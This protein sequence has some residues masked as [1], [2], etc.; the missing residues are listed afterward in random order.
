MSTLFFNLS[1]Q[2]DAFE[3]IQLILDLFDHVFTLPTLHDLTQV[4]SMFSNF[5][6]AGICKE[7]FV[8][9]SCNHN[10]MSFVTFKHY[11]VSPHDNIS[12]LFQK[13][14]KKNMQYTCNGCQTQ[15]M[16]VV[17]CSL[18]D[19][20]KILLLLVNRFSTSSLYHRNRKNKAP[21]HIYENIR[22]GLV[23]YRLIALIEHHGVDSQSGHYTCYI[24]GHNDM[25]Y[26]CNDSV[27]GRRDLAGT[28]E[29]AYLLFFIHS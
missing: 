17:T 27:V 26:H 7:V 22:F 21:M 18:H 28:S 5:F 10:N 14:N 19:Y 24:R 2:R 1:V 25:W 8:C 23:D 9:G 20:P 6:F 11:T 29:N 4:G 12:I 13:N 16:Q 3:A 15:N